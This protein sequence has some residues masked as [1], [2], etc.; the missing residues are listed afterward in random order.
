MDIAFKWRWYDA[1]KTAIVYEAQGL[2]TWKDY[3]AIVRISLFS[4]PRTGQP[5][6]SIV[7]LRGSTRQ[8]MPSGLLG[9]V[10]SFGK[11][12]HPILSGRAIC[13]GMTPAGEREL[14]L[15]EGR[16]LPTPDGFVQF[17][18]DD[19]SLARLLAQWREEMVS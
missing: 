16:I 1:E 15:V 19:E 3:H 12:H 4:L 14:Q 9:H 5:I 13:I 7:D 2:W 11:K 10:R 18:D 8:Q 17:V 6:H